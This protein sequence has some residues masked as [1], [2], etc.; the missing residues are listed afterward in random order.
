[1]AL[2]GLQEAPAKPPVKPKK[3]K[4]GHH[5]YS[6]SMTVDDSTRS[7]PPLLDEKKGAASNESPLL[8]DKKRARN[9]KPESS[10]LNGYSRNAAGE[11]DGVDRVQVKPAARKKRGRAIIPKSAPGAE[12]EGQVDIKPI[13][14]KTKPAKRTKVAIVPDIKAELVA[15]DVQ[16]GGAK[17]SRA[18][19]AAARMRIKEEVS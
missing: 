12:G 18:E 4:A 7:Y 10:K 19:R 15:V 9:H 8:A 16:A 2:Y 17:K 6:G 3:F 14:R 1:M 5:P 11:D 13:I